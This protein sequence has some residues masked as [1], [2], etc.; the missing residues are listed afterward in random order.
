MTLLV[1][2]KGMEGQRIF[3]SPENVKSIRACSLRGN[4]SEVRTYAKGSR[5]M[6]VEGEVDY[7][8]QLLNFKES[9]DDHHNEND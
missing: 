8:K 1:E 6:V 9:Q 3:V 5:L 4:C 7:L 2:L